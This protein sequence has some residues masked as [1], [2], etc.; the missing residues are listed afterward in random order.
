L[1]L[2]DKV[3][4]RLR[5]AGYLAGTV[6]VKVR[7]SD[8]V[9]VSR[10]RALQTPSDLATDLYPEVRSLFESVDLHGLPV[11]LLGVRAEKLR[12]SSKTSVQQTL[13]QSVSTGEV[14]A[15]ELALDEIRARFGSS[16]IKLG[17]QKRAPRWRDDHEHG[18]EARR[19]RV[20]QAP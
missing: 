5:A 12:R 16:A 13:E 11:R 18:V 17:A 9:T 14:R 1:A 3:A 15:A 4:G 2:T 8:F 20:Q 10:S 7:T 6:A 19:G